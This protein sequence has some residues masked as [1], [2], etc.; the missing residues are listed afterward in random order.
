MSCPPTG[1]LACPLSERI[2]VIAGQEQRTPTQPIT[3]LVDILAKI[4]D[5]PFLHYVTR[6]HTTWMHPCGRT[7]ALAGQHSWEGTVALSHRV[8]P[9]DFEGLAAALGLVARAQVRS[10]TLG[11]LKIVR[12]H[13]N[14]TRLKQ[15]LY[16]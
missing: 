4:G 9:A 14:Q 12:T 3:P 5:P 2:V 7:V 6:F 1:I 10:G 15:T 16:E 13:V 8:E 11:Q